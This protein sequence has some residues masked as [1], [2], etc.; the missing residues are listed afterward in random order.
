MAQDRF[1]QANSIN[2]GILHHF[3]DSRRTIT[4][5][6]LVTVSMRLQ[7]PL[8]TKHS[9]KQISPTKHPAR[10]VKRSAI[11]KSANNVKPSSKRPKVGLVVL[12]SAWHPNLDVTF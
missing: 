2:N 10:D 9:P 11:L 4:R 12:C 6:P 7:T 8:T 3:R 1:D 5:P